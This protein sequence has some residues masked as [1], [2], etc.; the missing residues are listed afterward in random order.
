[1]I[2]EK[3]PVVRSDIPGSHIFG[4]AQV[5]SVSEDA[6]RLVIG[7]D[8]SLRGEINSCEHLIIEGVV[9]ADVFTAS[10]MDILESG[11][12]RGTAE[13]CDCVI[14]GNFEG[15]LTVHGRL[16]VKSTGCI[17]GEIEYGMIEIDAGGKIEGRM[18][19][20]APP[21]VV[22]TSTPAAETNAALSGNVEPLFS[23]ESE[24]EEA[25]KSQSG[26][27]RSAIYRRSAGR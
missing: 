6:R 11:L 13:V 22:E 20:I 23:P 2:I 19:F 25:A 17:Q 5:A 16:T 27:A 14:A 26:I 12:F 1:M 9:Q 18:T 4:A 10:R 21:A 8:I 15:K 24:D 7:R 3:K